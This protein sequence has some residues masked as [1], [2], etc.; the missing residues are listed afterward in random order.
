MAGDV[1]PIARDRVLD[2]AERL[3][4]ARG[5]AA[6]T[7]RDVAQAVGLN[8]ASLYYHVPGGKE[9]LYVEVM[10]RGLK[11]HHD[12]LAQAINEAG[13]DW[14][15]QLHAAA[16]WLVAQP[17]LDIARVRLS[18]LPALSADNAARLSRSMYVMLLTPIERIFRRVVGLDQPAKAMLLTGMF[19]FMVEGVH[20]AP[21][22]EVPMDRARMVD[23]MLDVLVHGL[24]SHAKEI[25]A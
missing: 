17:P 22:E 2:G 21:P 16:H 15:A 14:Q 4:A 12:G 5:Y 11:R 10:E 18:D 9:A 3:F 7:L 6:V 1:S 8:H 19:L 20:S 24:R 25:S 13:D 23:M